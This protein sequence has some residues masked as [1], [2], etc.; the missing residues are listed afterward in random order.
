MTAGEITRPGG[1]KS[2]TDLAMR[3]V[4]ALIVLVLA[5]QALHFWLRDPLHYVIDYSTTSFGRFWPR[6]FVLLPHIAGGTVALFSGPF[7]L[8][9]GLRRKHLRIHRATGYAYISGVF[10][11]GGTAF[12]LAFHADPPVSGVPLFFMA[13]AWWTTIAM[14]F[15]AIRGRQ[16]DAHRQWMI[17]SY[18]LTFAFVTVRYVTDLPVIAPLGDDRFT[19]ANWMCWTIPLFV[20]EVALQ[21]RRT[22]GPRRAP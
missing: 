13:A 20:T 12:V 16:I 19:L 7:Q 11:A 2:I 5:Y 6:R 8:W 3:A 1:E 17:R 22:I 21:W 9:S 10:L 14:A 18:V 4:S 15:V